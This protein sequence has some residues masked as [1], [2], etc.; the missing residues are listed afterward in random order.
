VTT[1][2]DSQYIVLKA[3]ETRFAIACSYPPFMRW[4]VKSCSGFICREE[5]HLRL[6]LR[7][8][9][10]P[11]GDKPGQ[12][13]YTMGIGNYGKNGELNISM[14]CVYP[15]NS[16]NYW[17]MLRVCLQCAIAAK[18]P[19]D[20]FLHSAGIVWGGMA[21]IFAG[22]SGAGKST[23]CKLLV[24]DPSFTVLHDEMVAITQEKAGFRAWSTPIWG[25]APAKYS[26]SAP[27]KAVFF[28]RQD[29]TN[30]ATKLSGRES[31]N[32]LILSLVPLYNA[33]NGRLELGPSESVRLTLE[34]AEC[35]PCYELHFQ[36]ERSFWECI[37][38]L[39][40]KGSET[41]R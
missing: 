38:P 19:P 30:Y 26:T 33:T 12:L 27:L 2:P 6:N 16:D 28:L 37:S 3:A 36:P 15:G 9:S 35:I 29:R 14:A 39:F 13:T 21:Y 22:V 17:L 20:L 8:V 40:E 18:Q 41:T 23:V 11:R 24:G 31:A 34:L 1:Q 32:Q 10:I 5:P 4:L 25:E 7:I